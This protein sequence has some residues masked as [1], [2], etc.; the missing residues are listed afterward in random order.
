M[1]VRFLVKETS[2]GE[3]TLDL[4]DD[5]T[6]EQLDDVRSTAINEVIFDGKMDVEIEKEYVNNKPVNLYEMLTEREI[7]FE[8]E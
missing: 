2:Y 5:Y 8:K 3:I 1:K 7:P 6:E 4:P